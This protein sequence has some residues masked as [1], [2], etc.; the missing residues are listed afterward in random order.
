MSDRYPAGVT[1]ETLD[2][3]YGDTTADD[4]YQD[5][6]NGGI[7]FYEDDEERR[8]QNFD[9]VKDIWERWHHH[10]AKFGEVAHEWFC[11]ERDRAIADKMGE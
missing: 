10:P 9:A 2:K 5:F 6:N 7:D 4:L 11:K 3:L 8:G 1:D